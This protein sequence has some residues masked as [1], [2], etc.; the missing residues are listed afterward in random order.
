MPLD[1]S[2]KCLELTCIHIIPV[3]T[4]LSMFL[5]CFSPYCNFHGPLAQNFISHFFRHLTREGNIS[6]V[7]AQS[8]LKL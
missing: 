4:Q 2:N 1:F 8:L 7:C 3:K 6:I 5:F